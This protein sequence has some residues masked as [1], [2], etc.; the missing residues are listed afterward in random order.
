MVTLDLGNLCVWCQKD[1]SMG[2]GRFVNR[3]TVSTD[4]ESVEWLTK[5]QAQ[6]YDT[7]EGYCCPECG[8]YDCDKCNEPIPLDEDITDT[9]ELGH[10][11]TWCLPLE[12]WRKEALE[13]F[14]NEPESVQKYYLTNP[15]KENN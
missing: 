2:S 4:T 6:Q 15:T 14:N 12:K 7:V 10:Y 1:T 3:Y 9:E 11:H 5:E 8:G 13:W